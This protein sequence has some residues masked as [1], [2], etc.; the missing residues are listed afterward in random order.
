MRGGITS[1]GSSYQRLLE[2]LNGNLAV[3]LKNAVVEGA[4]YDILA[5][6]LLAWFYSGAALED[7]TKIDCTMALFLLNDGVASTDSLYIETSKMVATGSALLNLADQSLDVRF[8]PRSKTRK[9][10]VPSSIRVKGNFEKPK[11][12]IS[13]VAAAADAYAEILSL[14]PQLV[15]RIFGSDRRKRIERPCDPTPA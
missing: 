3:S 4:A 2:T 9:L 13:P 11:V 10:Q 14:L 6:D 12:T 5:T 15:R 7:S 8:T 1:Q